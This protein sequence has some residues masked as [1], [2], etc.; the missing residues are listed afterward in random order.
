M[1]FNN[2]LGR[3]SIGVVN[4]CLFQSRKASVMRKIRLASLRKTFAALCARP[5]WVNHVFGKW[6]WVD[7]RVR[8]MEVDTPELLLIVMVFL[9]SE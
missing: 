5:V 9:G 8:G 4:S 3:S 2:S 1:S 7:E 6:N